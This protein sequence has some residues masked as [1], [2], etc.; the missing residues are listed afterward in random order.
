MKNKTSKPSL[1]SEKR[2]EVIRL[3]LSILLLSLAVYC[4]GM[5]RGFISSV[6][7]ILLCPAV[8]TLF[9]DE[10][11]YNSIITAVSALLFSVTDRL[12]TEY[13]VMFTLGTTAAAVLAMLATRMLKRAFYGIP[14]KMKV[15]SLVSAI[16]IFCALNAA[17]FRICG[18][19]VTVLRQRS[20]S[21]SYISE[22]YPD[23][24]FSS[25]STHYDVSRDKYITVLTYLDTGS[26]LE[27]ELFRDGDLWN[28][29]YFEFL[30]QNALSARRSELIS[31]IRED[32]DDR[33]SFREAGIAIDNNSEGAVALTYGGD[34]S[35]LYG[36]MSFDISVDFATP[37]RR[38]FAA[39][40][41]HIAKHLIDNGFV[42][43]KIKFYGGDDDS[44]LFEYLLT[45]D[46]DLDNV[47]A[48][49]KNFN[50]DEYVS[51]S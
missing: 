46:S 41:T 50:A 5:L 26:E 27:S 38:D 13:T 12:G 9:Y 22:K 40:C 30:K 33:L 17:F 16:L 51:Y 43:D 8:V 7:L 25:V 29:G 48:E 49:V 11:L 10:P 15:F 31:L 44:Y 20:E 42:F 45:P 2:M 14:R 18:N 34:N 37:L 28:D 47:F 6:P 32:N 23:K 36:K 19:P 4:T 39:Y 21:K 35:S 3:A 24:E 1:R